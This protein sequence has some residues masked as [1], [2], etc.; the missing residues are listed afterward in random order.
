MIVDREIY[1]MN[2]RD[3]DIPLSGLFIFL[4]NLLD[5][6]TVIRDNFKEK[7]KLLKY[8]IHDC[9]FYKETKGVLISKNKAM[10]PKCKNTNTREN[11]LKL[12]NIL[13]LNNEEGMH[14]LIRYLKSYIGETFWRTPRKTDW[15]ISVH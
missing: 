9:L 2:A 14:I 6:F 1:E 13:C 4:R 12:L 8:L 3:E 10:P 11:C 7:N 15:G 5:K